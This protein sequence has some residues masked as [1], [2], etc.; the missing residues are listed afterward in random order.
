M[1][2]IRKGGIKLVS[3]NRDVVKEFYEE[4]WRY[5]KRIKHTV[6]KF[7]PARLKIACDWIKPLN[8]NRKFHVLDIGCGEGGLGKLLRDKYKGF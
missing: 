3:N 4:Y 7:T 2:S 8:P 5:R 1:C 6:E